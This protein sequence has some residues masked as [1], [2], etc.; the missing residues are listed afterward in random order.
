M[1]HARPPAVAGGG[2]T[3]LRVVQHVLC[4]MAYM[5]VNGQMK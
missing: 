1:C 3:Q 2:L 4:L 5:A